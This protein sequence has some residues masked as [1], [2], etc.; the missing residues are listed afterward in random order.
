MSTSVGVPVSAGAGRQLSELR[1]QV[2]RRTGRSD[3]SLLN[4]AINDALRELSNRMFFN[5]L[6]TT[7]TTSLASGEYYATLAV[8]IAWLLELRLENDEQSYQLVEYDEKEYKFLYPD[9][10]TLSSGDP[11]GYWLDASGVVYLDTKVSAARDLVG[12]YWKRHP[13]LSDDTDTLEILG[14]DHGVVALA[15]AIVFENGEQFTSAAYWRSAFQGHLVSYQRKEQRRPGRVMYMG[16]KPKV[17]QVPA[18]Y[19]NMPFVK[20]VE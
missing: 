5:D 7:G 11:W 1:A 4:D 8:D 2:Q 15:T 10:D 3:S 14:F 18:N 17:N 13:V 9:P 20:G 6:M 19:W 16:Q 12:T